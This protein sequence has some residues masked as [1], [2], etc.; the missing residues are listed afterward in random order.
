MRRKLFVV[1]LVFAAA[2]YIVEARLSAHHAFASEFDQNAPV[3]L[4]GTL[5][6][7]E[8]VNPHAW[9]HLDVKDPKTGEIQKWRVEGGAP[10]NLLRRGWTKNMIPIGDEIYIEGYRAKEPGAFRANGHILETVKDGKAFFMG[11]SG[12]GAP[13]ESQPNV[14]YDPNGRP[15]LKKNQ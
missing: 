2:V 4:Q 11:S 9:I 13:Y 3:S 6:K 1:P 14:Q 15:V 5:T 8:W 12:T 7:M 10:N